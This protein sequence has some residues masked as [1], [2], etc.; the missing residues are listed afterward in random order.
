MFVKSRDERDVLVDCGYKLTS[1]SMVK[2]GKIKKKMNNFMHNLR[3]DVPEAQSWVPAI[4]IDPLRIYQPHFPQ[5]DGFS[6][7]G[8]SLDGI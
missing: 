5:E 7:I 2:F 1:S 3:M 4:Y 6:I 8:I